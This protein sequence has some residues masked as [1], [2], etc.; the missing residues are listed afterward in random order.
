MLS[1]NKVVFEIDNP[2]EGA[3]TSKYEISRDDR[4][5]LYRHALSFYD[6]PGRHYHDELHIDNMLDAYA[7]N[8]KHSMSDALFLAIIMHDAVYIPGQSP[9][10][11]EASLSLVPTLYASVMGKSIP[12]TLCDDVFSLIRWTLPSIHVQDKRKSFSSAVDE[13]SL[14]RQA[15]I[16]LDLDLN[17]MSKSWESFMRTQINIDKEFMHLGTEEDRRISSAK[18]LNTFVEKG[19]VYYTEEMKSYNNQALRNLRAYIHEIEINKN[20]DFERMKTCNRY[21]LRV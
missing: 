9:M 5:R 14:N 8:F 18:F 4:Y 7:R 20:Y 17:G 13:L 12:Q 6:V 15:A 11:E 21:D 3:N 2:P 16:I 10:S 19:F 1:F